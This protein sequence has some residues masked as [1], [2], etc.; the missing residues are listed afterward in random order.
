MHS[1]I[2]LGVLIV[3][4]LVGA[5][6]AMF[7]AQAARTSPTTW[8]SRRRPSSSR[9]RIVV[10]FLY[11]NHLA[12]AGTYDF[13]SRH[14]LSA[15]LGL[16]YDVGVDG[17]SL[18]MVVLTA[19]VLFLA[20]LGARERRREASFVGWL[21]LLTSF[22]MASFVSHDVL[23]FFIFFELTLVPSYFIIANW[24]GAQR[25]RAALKFFIYTFSGSA[26]LLD[27]HLVPRLRAPAPDRGSAHLLLHARSRAR[28]SATAPRCGCSSPLRSPSP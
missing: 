24:G 3:V 21:L 2:Y 17:I 8:R 26:F 14:V 23:E 15:P 16:A 25:A 11:N 9:S 13:M 12:G 7:D 1:S 18:F 6:V 28:R 22:T 4:P 19:L 20:L 27:R 10:A 5:L